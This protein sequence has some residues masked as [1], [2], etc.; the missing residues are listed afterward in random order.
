MNLIIFIFIIQ[1][2]QTY[3]YQISHSLIVGGAP[4]FKKVTSNQ[5]IA[6]FKPTEGY[7]I[8]KYFKKLPKYINNDS[9][10]KK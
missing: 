10:E 2:F 8:T 9:H 5:Q 4:Q 3:I 6:D 7:L 1:G